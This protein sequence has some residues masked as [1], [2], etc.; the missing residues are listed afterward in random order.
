MQINAMNISFSERKQN[1]NK[2]NSAKKWVFFSYIYFA[3]FIANHI[4]YIPLVSIA[5][6]T[7]SIRFL[8]MSHNFR[9]HLFFRI[10]WSL[11]PC[12]EDAAMQKEK[13]ASVTGD[14]H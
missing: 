3:A 5:L 14:A 12:V 6:S 8:R 1:N 9:S 13:L 10:F 11:C 7:F 2:I 4:E